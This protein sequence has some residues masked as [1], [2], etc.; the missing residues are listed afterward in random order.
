MFTTGDLH[1]HKKKKKNTGDLNLVIE[2]LLQHKN[3]INNNTQL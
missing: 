2:N 1:S 3:L